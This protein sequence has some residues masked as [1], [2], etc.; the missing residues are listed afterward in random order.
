MCCVMLFSVWEINIDE[1]GQLE[2]FNGAPLLYAISVK[3][4][5]FMG[6][7]T[8]EKNTKVTKLI[9]FENCFCSEHKTDR[10]K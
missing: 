1:A 10:Y 7:G 3:I 5:S 8:L 2:G 6:F 4:L 9:C